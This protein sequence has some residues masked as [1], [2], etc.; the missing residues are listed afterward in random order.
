MDSSLCG[1]L[2]LLSA[3]NALYGI[4]G[5]LI[6]PRKRMAGLLILLLIA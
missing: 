3:L 4:T 2:L 6:L 5:I 1:N